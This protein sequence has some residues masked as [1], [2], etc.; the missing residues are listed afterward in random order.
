MP[1]C[2]II[3]VEA[4]A[5][6]TV[7]TEEEEI[8]GVAD[9]AV[10]TATAVA[11]VI[12]ACHSA[13]QE[14]VEGM[15]TIE[16][17]EEAIEAE[18]IEEAAVVEG[19]T[20]TEVVEEAVVAETTAIAAV[21]AIVEVEVVVVDFNLDHRVPASIGI[22]VSDPVMAMQLANKD[23]ITVQVNPSPPP[24]PTFSRPRTPSQNPSWASSKPIRHIPCARDMEP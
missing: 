9:A 13:Q 22:S 14:V 10:V 8:V 6:E 23:F 11:V 16:V 18:V 15:I 12:P 20:A 1:S 21:E 3:V 4:E 24:M 7:E 2:P 19:T 5:V 17:V